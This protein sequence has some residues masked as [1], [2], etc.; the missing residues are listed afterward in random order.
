VRH[1]VL[2]EPEQAV[3]DLPHD[4]AD[5]G[6]GEA[7]RVLELVEEFALADLLHLELWLALECEARLGVAHGCVRVL[8]QHADQVVVQSLLAHRDFV[9]LHAFLSGRHFVDVLL[10]EFDGELLFSLTMFGKE[11]R[12]LMPVSKFLDH[13]KFL[14][15]YHC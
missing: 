1:A 12:S 15:D 6:F 10:E 4:D 3:H 9:A 11:C 5:R 13:F 2:L 8:R 7:V 14:V